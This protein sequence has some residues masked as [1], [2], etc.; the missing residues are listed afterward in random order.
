MTVNDVLAF[1]G[2][3]VTALG[4]GGVIVFG[5]SGFLGKLWAERLMANAQ[6]E[7]AREL[8]AQTDTL[9]RETEQVLGE[10]KLILEIAKDKHLQLFHDRRVAYQEII[11]LV[12]EVLASFD[13][14]ILLND[15]NPALKMLDQNKQRIRIFGYMSL[16][17]PQSVLDT[18]ADLETY[19]LEVAEGS[20]P[21]AWEK[22]REL[23]VK[24]LN[25]MRGDLALEAGKI[26]YTGTR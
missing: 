21:Y 22:A 4:G 1:V 17:A 25:E 15:G 11:D 19:L 3:T 2:L 23:S 12:A 5:L 7:N 10:L 8:A 26:A 6:A 16:V 24:L 20:T 14:S 13:R 9:R 18:F